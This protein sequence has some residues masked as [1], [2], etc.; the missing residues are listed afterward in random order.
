VLRGLAADQRAARE[1]ASGGDA[2][3]DFGGDRDVEPL[4][5]VVVEEEQRLRALDQDVVDAHRDEIDADGVVP[6]QREREL[7]LGADA[8]GAR[9]Q[10]GLPVALGQPDQRA[11]S[12]DA[13]EHLGAHRPLRER[14]D[15]LDERVA[16]VD[17]DARFAV[18]ERGRR[19]WNGRCHRRRGQ[20][21]RQGRRRRAG[22]SGA[23]PTR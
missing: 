12:A 3:D 13:G 14:L 9:H 7:Q 1:L 17:V 5:D 2:L 23:P 10:H 21:G 6:V 16:G 15:P 18:R 19:G 4:A 22:L 11:E 20:S 8:V